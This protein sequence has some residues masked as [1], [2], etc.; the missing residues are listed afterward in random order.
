MGSEPGSSRQPGGETMSCTRRGFLKTIGAAMVGLGLTRME[1]L[2]AFAASSVNSTGTAELGGPAS[3]PYSI[4][5]LRA[6]AVVAAR[7]AGDDSLATE[8]QDVC[9]WAPAA[10]AL[11]RRPMDVQTRSAERFFQDFPGGDQLAQIMVQT[12]NTSWRAPR[13]RVDP[14]SLVEQHYD[15]LQRRQGSVRA[16]IIEPEELQSSASKADLGLM[17]DRQTGERLAASVDRAEPMWAALSIFSGMMLDPTDDLS[18]RLTP[19]LS[20]SR[21]NDRA[22]ARTATIRY[23][24]IVIGAVQRAVWADQLQ[25]ANPATPLVQLSAA[26]LLPIGEEDGRLLLLRIAG[27]SQRLTGYQTGSV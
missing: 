22:I 20:L 1:P 11:R 26:G 27:R 8:L 19:R 13:F 18:K 5:A 4:D 14:D 12:N 23:S 10:T 21:A 9:C 25:G 17:L 3:G 2:R 24:Q 16:L 7:F 15:Q 6:R